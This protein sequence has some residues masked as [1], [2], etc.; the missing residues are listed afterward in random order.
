MTGY[1]VGA[2]D[3]LYLLFR[4][5]LNHPEAR[6]WFSSKDLAPLIP[7][8]AEYIQDRVPRFL[9]VLH[10]KKTAGHG[11]GLEADVKLGEAL[12]NAGLFFDCHEY[13]EGVWREKQGD[14]KTFLQ[15]VIQVAAAMHKLELDPKAWE[16]ALYLI[17]HGM[18]KIEASPRFKG[19]AGLAALVEIRN[20]VVAEQIDLADLPKLHVL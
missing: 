12:F 20:R 6:Q 8:H 19:H 1:P 4:A 15:G 18:K 17:D 11:D 7:K 5:F 3:A 10:W 9:K 16:G 14:D 2:R 13:L